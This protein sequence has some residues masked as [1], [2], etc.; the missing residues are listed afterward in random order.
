MAGT[1][2]KLDA[3]G[4]LVLGPSYAN[5]TVLVEEVAHGEI[6]V[7]MAEVIPVGEAWLFKNEEALSLVKEGLSQAKRGKVA[8]GSLN[9]G[10]MSWVDKLKD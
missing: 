4:R 2:K 10:S 3:K 5:A 9:K 8:K 1:A 6:R 7:R